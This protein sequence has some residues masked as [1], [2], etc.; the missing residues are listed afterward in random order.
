MYIP[1]RNEI[2]MRSDLLEYAQRNNL[3]SSE[4]KKITKN[5]LRHVMR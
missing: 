1:N 4:I 2:H 5:H 3:G